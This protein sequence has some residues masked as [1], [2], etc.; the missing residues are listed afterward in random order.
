LGKRQKKE[1]VLTKWDKKVAVQETM[2]VRPS[3][4]SSKTLGGP[5][6]WEENQATQIGK[7]KKKKTESGSHG[8]K[9]FM[10]RKK[11]RKQGQGE[12]RK[13]RNTQ[14]K[15]T[16]LRRSGPGGRLRAKK[17]M[18]EGGGGV[19]LRS[20]NPTPTKDGKRR[21]FG[22]G[23]DFPPK[24]LPLRAGLLPSPENYEKKDA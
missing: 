21:C 2:A 5:D 16:R 8:R 14:G 7:D 13:G 4:D 22:E 20:Q 24:K 17:G 3:L 1:R 18:T 10:G 15:G 23:K 9:N 11:G 6:I 19:P 12:K